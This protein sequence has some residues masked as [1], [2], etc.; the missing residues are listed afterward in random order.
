MLFCQ[1]C[2]DSH[3]LCEA[4]MYCA[5][6]TCCLRYHNTYSPM[7]HSINTHHLKQ[8][9][10]RRAN[11]CRYACNCSAQSCA[12]TIAMLSFFWHASLVVREGANSPLKHSVSELIHLVLSH[13]SV[14][15]EGAN[16]LLKHS[17]QHTP[18]GENT[19]LGGLLQRS[20]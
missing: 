14:V 5:P 6:I 3:I 13:P 19:V 15:R 4:D 20:G 16:S 18:G 7:T 1:C 12:Y 9:I 2:P 17:T 8:S 11:P 10:I